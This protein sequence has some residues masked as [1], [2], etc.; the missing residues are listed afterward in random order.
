[1]SIFRH[2]H[3][4]RR[5][6]PSLYAKRRLLFSLADTAYRAINLWH[7]NVL[8]SGHKLKLSFLQKLDKNTMFYCGDH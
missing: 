6:H 2:I 5:E 3:H 4:R 7:V 8:S 1:M